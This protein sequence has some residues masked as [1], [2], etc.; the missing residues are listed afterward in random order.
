MVEY[1]KWISIDDYL[2]GINVERILYLFDDNETIEFYMR[3]F[4][5]ITGDFAFGKYRTIKKLKVK[6][7]MAIEI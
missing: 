7:W 1:H 3:P 5:N 4:P 6:A 2:P